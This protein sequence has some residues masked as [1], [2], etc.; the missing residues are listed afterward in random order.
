MKEENKE[1]LKAFITFVLVVTGIISLAIFL[2][3]LKE[4]SSRVCKR[5]VKT[6][7]QL[8]SH[9]SWSPIVGWHY[10]YKQEKVCIKWV[11]VIKKEGLKR[12]L[13]LILNSMLYLSTQRCL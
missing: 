13:F 9:L 2:F 7:T 4:P 10:E 8:R 1:A 5:C 12:S 3:T 6:E 11:T